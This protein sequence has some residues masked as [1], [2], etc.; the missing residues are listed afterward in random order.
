[1]HKTERAVK[2]IKREIDILKT[3]K[4]PSLMECYGTIETEKAYYLITEYC[5]NGELFDYVSK[6]DQLSE[7]QAVEFFNQLISGVE[8][9]HE[10]GICH[11]DLKL[12]NILLDSHNNVKIADFG[13]SV[14]FEE[15]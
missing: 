13:M 14:L 9:M 12:E 11:R 4:H 6:W 10:M 8:Y 5:E 1:M 15:G 3:A 2:R 7:N